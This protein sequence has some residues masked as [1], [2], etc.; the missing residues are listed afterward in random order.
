VIASTVLRELTAAAYQKDDG[1]RCISPVP[2]DSKPW[3]K[4][5]QHGDPKWAP[6]RYLDA[7]GQLLFFVV[8]FDL[9]AIVDAPPGSKAPKVYMP[10]SYWEK[11]DGSFHW[12]WKRI[13]GA[14]PLFNLDRLARSPDAPVIVVEGEKCA[15]AAARMARFASCVV[16][17]WHGGAAG[18][19]G[20]DWWP[21]AGRDVLI[22]PDADRPEPG[23]PEG[24]G[25]YAAREVARRALIV[26]ATCVRIAEIPPGLPHGFDLADLAAS[27]AVV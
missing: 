25:L 18:V 13:P 6:W 15:D 11:A 1:W 5:P 19:A 7:E 22:W 16:I 17:T 8:R 14:Q 4:H 9:P 27:E 23:Y 21:L 24:K 10:R 26:G 2:E 20:V 12:R 3:F